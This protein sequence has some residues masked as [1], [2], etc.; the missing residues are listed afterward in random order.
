VSSMKCSSWVWNQMLWHFQQYLMHAGEHLSSVL[1]LWLVCIGCVHHLV[2][3]NSLYYKSL[4]LCMIMALYIIGHV[5]K[6]ISHFKQSPHKY[7]WLTIW[8]SP[9]CVLSECSYV[10]AAPWLYCKADHLPLYSS[11]KIMNCSER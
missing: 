5:W 7:S 4:I 8:A 3:C 1:I 9:C 11:C 2:L 6:R 10:I